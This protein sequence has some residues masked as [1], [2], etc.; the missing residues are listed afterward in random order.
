[1]ARLDPDGQHLWSHAYRGVVDFVAGRGMA[2]ATVAVAPSG[3]VILGGEF[4]GT[5]DFGNGPLVATSASGDGFVAAFDPS[6]DPLW[7]AR[8]GDLPPVPGNPSIVLAGTIESLAVDALGYVLALGYRASGPWGGM[9]V[10]KLDPEGQLVWRRDVSTTGTFG[11]TI[12]ADAAGNAFVAGLAYAP[13]DFGTGPLPGSSSATTFFRAKLDP[14]GQTAWSWGTLTT[15]LSFFPG[16]A[17]GLDP[18]GNGVIAGASGDP[19]LDVGCGPAPAGWTTRV[20][21]F[22]AATGRCRWDAGFTGA[23]VALSVDP[24]GTAFLAEDSGARML[25]YPDTGGSVACDHTF[26]QNPRTE[27]YGLAALPSGRVLVT[28]GFSDTANFVEDP[29]SAV[30]SAGLRDVFLASF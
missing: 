21:Q 15:E 8:F 14:A 12:R 16:N 2:S 6:G 1:M 17:M 26:T 7:S 20:M 23:G 30:K 25:A 29:A 4:S 11:A 27:V 24:A 28:G 10:V 5:V 22:D 3:T 18:A 9:F 19:G 13:I